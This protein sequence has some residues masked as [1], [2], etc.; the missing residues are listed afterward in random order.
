MKIVE[1][2]NVCINS[3][4]VLEARVSEIRNDSFSIEMFYFLRYV[5]GYQFVQASRKAT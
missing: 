2:L 4:F 5:T 3:D 1:Q